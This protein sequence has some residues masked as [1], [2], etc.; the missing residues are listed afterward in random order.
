[1]RLHFGFIPKQLSQSGLISK[2]NKSE[3]GAPRCGRTAAI[4]GFPFDGLSVRGYKVPNNNIYEL[5]NALLFLKQTECDRL[6]FQCKIRT[7]F[8]LGPQ[9]IPNIAINEYF[10]QRLLPSCPSPPTPSLCHAPPSVQTGVLSASHCLSSSDQCLSPTHSFPEAQRDHQPVTSLTGRFVL[11]MTIQKKTLFVSRHV[12]ECNV[13]VW[14]FFTR[15]H[16][17]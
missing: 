12:N 8:N 16:I 4:Q 15:D 9:Q 7:I 2:R 3:R 6:S 11:L 5:C 10:L 13:S 14:R 17:G 1:M